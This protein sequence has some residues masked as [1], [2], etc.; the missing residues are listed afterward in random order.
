M[1]TISSIALCALFIS[2]VLSFG[3]QSVATSPTSPADTPA[4][5]LVQVDSVP[6]ASD[7]SAIHRKIQLAFCLDATGSMSELIAAA[8]EKIWSITSSIAQS[9]S[10]VDLE[11]AFVF[12]RDRGDRF[13]TRLIPLGQEIDSLYSILMD[14]EADGGGDLPESVNEALHVAV[15]KL[16]WDGNDSVYKTIFLVGDCPPHMNY[17]DDVKYPVSC[18]AANK[19]GITINTILMGDNREARRVWNELKN[20][21]NG[22]FMQVGMN[23]NNFEIGTPYDD[24]IDMYQRQLDDT[25]LY[26]GYN[27]EANSYKKMNA[28]KISSGSTKAISAKRAEFYNTAKGEKVYY[29][30]YE[31]I[32]DTKSNSKLIDTI[33]VKLLPDKFKGMTRDQIKAETARMIAQRNAFTVKIKLYTALRDSFITREL[34]KRDSSEV[35]GS[36]NNIV[37]ENIKTQAADKKIILKGKAKF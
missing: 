23:A 8:K 5:S 33:D 26:Y 21:S 22:S 34:K 35:Q 36:F 9:D 37:F 16:K 13:V 1:K 25:R 12:Y 11:I 27:A 14:I 32:N 2:I 18:A 31:W 4:D 15:T 6:P 30:S 28:D 19:K 3:C 24:S 17:Q 10:T 29:G 20:C 7:E